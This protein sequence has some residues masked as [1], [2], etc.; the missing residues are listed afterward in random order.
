MHTLQQLRAGQLHGARYLKLSA[1]LQQ[2]PREIF[3]LADTL[4]VLDLSGNALAELPEDFPRLQR[5]RVLFC[6]N[7]PFLQLPSVLGQCAQLSMIGFKACSIESVPA[8]SLPPNLR[9]LILTDNRIESL[10][11]EI[12]QCG[13]LQKLMLAGN[14]LQMLPP[15]LADC[16]KLELLRIA[17]NRLQQLPAWLAN[18][19]RLTWLA[20]AGNPFSAAQEQAGARLPIPAIAW[21]QLLLGEKLGEGAS[22]QI[23]QAQLQDGG[24]LRPLALKLFKGEVTS[25]G[26]AASEMAACMAAGEH[27][28]LIPLLGHLRDHP[29]QTPG[30]LLALIDPAFKVLAGP[31]S[32]ES[33]TR[34]CYPEEL[35]F[36]L[37]QVLLILTG[38]AS[39][40]RHLHQ[41]GIMHGDLYAHNI[42]FQPDG[43]VLLGDFGAASFLAAPGECWQRLEVRAF[44]L[45]M[46]ELL[47]RCLPL[48][49][50]ATLHA[51]LAELQQRCCDEIV[52]QRPLFAEIHAV[53]EQ[54]QAAVR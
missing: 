41:R 34:D 52:L 19:P 47:Q 2:F 13:Q 40:I 23:F 32:L 5:L 44:G 28:Q 48:P 27:P 33:C 50:F 20:Y 51:A 49:H 3:D 7:N 8:T 11:D 31:P 25:D 37:P 45:L 6:S 15:S 46:Q 24:V 36:S 30:L 17:A 10:P 53:L 54:C 4:E 35:R 22:G 26:L 29:L 42:L 43:Q 16:R 1:G 39:A 9:W 18:M 38:I 14:R 12:G 21:Q